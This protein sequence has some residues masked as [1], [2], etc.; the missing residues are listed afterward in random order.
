MGRSIY[1]GLIAPVLSLN[2]VS[3][4][5]AGTTFAVSPRREGG[6]RIVTWTFEPGADPADAITIVLE[7]GLRADANGDLLDPVQ[8]D[9]HTDPAN[10]M[11]N[12]VDIGKMNFVRA[13]ITSLT[14]G[15]S[16]DPVDS[17]INY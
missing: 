4:T 6:P 7:G 13:N 17:R 14:V 5:G 15:A 8:L 3:A 2:Q 11:E 16:M 10:R 9:V 1:P 12:T